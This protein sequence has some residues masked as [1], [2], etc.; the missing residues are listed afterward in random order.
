MLDRLSEHGVRADHVADCQPEQ[1]TCPA[2]YGPL[3]AGDACQIIAHRRDGWWDV[4]IVPRPTM[5][6]P[7]RIEATTRVAGTVDRVNVGGSTWAVIDG[8]RIEG[9][10]EHAWH[11]HG[12]DAARIGSAE[13]EVT[14][15]RN[16]PV[17]LRLVYAR[18]LTA[19]SCELPREER[20]RPKVAGMAVGSEL[21]EGAMTAEIPARATRTV[22]VGHEAQEAYSASCERFATAVTLD[23]D[24]E[25]VEVIAEHEVMREEELD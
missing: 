12:G 20:S 2:E 13:L 8:V 11:T 6:A 4:D 25:R 16:D 3:A 10:G 23:M 15:D 1:A 14:N 18:W 5:G 7:T 21:V 9:R 17:T 24:G 22:T 19:F